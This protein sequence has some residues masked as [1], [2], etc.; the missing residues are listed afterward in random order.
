M[1][2][3]ATAVL[4]ISFVICVASTS[5]TNA[6]SG[7][8]ITVDKNG[9]PASGVSVV[10]D[11][12]NLGKAGGTGTT[13]TST[14]GTTNSSGD[15]SNVLNLSNMGKAHYDVWEKE[16]V[17]GE[18]VLV[19]VPA[20]VT[21]KDDG[22]KKHRIGGFFW[23]GDGRD[24]VTIDTGTGTVTNSHSSISTG[25]GTTP[26]NDFR[27]QVGGNF[28]YYHES[29]ANFFGGAGDFAYTLPQCHRT[30]I[31]GDFTIDHWSGTD[32]SSNMIWYMGGARFSQP[33]SS[34]TLFA[35]GL[36]G[37]VHSSN[38]YSSGGSEGSTSSTS[39]YNAF[40]AKI[41]GGIDWNATPRVSVEMVKFDYDY[42]H[43]SGNSQ[44]NFDLSF[45][46]KFKF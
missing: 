1:K 26:G 11:L 15:V 30:A 35:E 22:C 3:I 18:T 9:Q 6:Q 4:L 25:T 37:G 24:H 7:G 21:P 13:G 31:V 43:F 44:N 42:S 32:T 19:I 23:W 45:G 29:D 12:S 27:F 10:L 2:R 20:G 5:T 16:C 36:L 40:G 41:G 17:N 14:T 33:V 28:N 38:T 39:S 34:F 8:S 46:V